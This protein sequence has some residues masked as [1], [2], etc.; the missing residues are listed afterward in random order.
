MA[1]RKTVRHFHEA[2]HLHELTFSCYR[3]MPVIVY[4]RVRFATPRATPFRRRW[5]EG[6]PKGG[7]ACAKKLGLLGGHDGQSGEPSAP[8]DNQT[9]NPRRGVT[10]API[11]LADLRAVQ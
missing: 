10:K 11:P 4:F 5:R 8:I 9:S 6:G 1:H 7:R 3:R 2:G